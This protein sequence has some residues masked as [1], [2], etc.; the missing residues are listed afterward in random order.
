MLQLFNL[1]FYWLPPIL[2]YPVSLTISIA[3][4][5]LAMRL[6]KTVWDVIGIFFTFFGGLLSRVVAFFD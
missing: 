6:L 5:I 2:Y 3:L 4:L 1:S